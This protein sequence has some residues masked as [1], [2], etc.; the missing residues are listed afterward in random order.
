[1]ANAILLSTAIVGFLSIQLGCG[2][3]NPTGSQGAEG[4][5]VRVSTSPELRAPWVLTGP[6]AF[7]RQGVG[8]LLLEDMWPGNYT[9]TWGDVP[10]YISPSTES[11]SVL[12]GQVREFVGVYVEQP[13]GVI[14]VDV[15]PD[16]VAVEW[17]IS[18]PDDF[19]GV[20]SAVLEDVIPG[21]Y[22]MT[23]PSLPLYDTPPPEE[24]SVSG[25]DTTTFRAEY[26]LTVPD[27]PDAV[28]SLFKEIQE[29]R[30]LPAYESLLGTHYLFIPQN[31]V[32]AYA[33]AT[34]LS[35]TSKIF[36]GVAGSNGFVVSGISVVAMEP[37]GVWEDTPANDPNFGGFS[38]SLYRTY[39]IQVDYS[40]AGQ[41]LVLRVQGPIIFYVHP[42]GGANAYSLLGVQDL[43]FGAKSAENATWTSVKEIYR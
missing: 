8:D 2:S 26:T 31:D 17:L 36:N 10:G 18:G 20:G 24:A 29:L 21:H 25:G 13:L 16:V 11:G 39:E 27:N 19:T 41:N 4:G 40:I 32:S 23:W 14:A 30:S 28:A 42:E 35:I 1:V 43:T 38:A 12:S 7:R 3:D 6:D 5:S 33:A 37:Q 15:D 9:I 22:E 34:E